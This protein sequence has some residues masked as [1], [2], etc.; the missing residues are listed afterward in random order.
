MPR[1]FRRLRFPIRQKI[2]EKSY[3]RISA[4]MRSR[5]EKVAIKT[6]EP[7]ISERDEV[8]RMFL[9]RDD[10]KT[11]ETPPTP[12]YTSDDN[13]TLPND[14]IQ[15]APLPEISLETR[16]AENSDVE[17]LIL[18][19]LHAA[20]IQTTDLAVQLPEIATNFQGDIPQRLQD[21]DPQ[22]ISGNEIVLNLES[23]L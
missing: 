8:D 18:P 3:D 16:F 15:T 12:D 21:M 4:I 11:L 5:E 13:I 14:V 1:R 22:Y 20:E 19:Q 2:R 23:N 6:T 17:N 7:D 10:V 9:N